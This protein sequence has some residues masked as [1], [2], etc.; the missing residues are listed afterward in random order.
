VHAIY[1]RTSVYPRYVQLL[2]RALAHGTSKAI[3]I[4]RSV[5][6]FCVRAM[7]FRP[8]QVE[9]VPLPMPR[10]SAREVRPEAVAA[11]RE[12]YGL[13]VDTPVVGAITRFYPEKATEV[14]VEAFAEVAR[15]VPAA[16]LLLVGDGPQRPVLEARARELGLADRIRFAGFQHDPELHVRLFRVTAV[17]SREEGLGMTAI[18]SLAA[19]VPVVA[20]RVGGLPEVVTHGRSGLLVPPDDPAALAGALVR[21]LAEPGLREQLALGARAESR[22]FTIDRFVDRMEALYRSVSRDGR[23]GRPRR[24]LH[25]P[26]VQEPRH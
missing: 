5:R 26:L 10:A 25:P 24:L 9:V 11:L 16:R 2:D 22:R 8:D 7:G 3:A 15:R 20:T 14:L 13:T 17:P 18:E 1:S 6:E 23:R 21:V 19:G 4:S 12:R